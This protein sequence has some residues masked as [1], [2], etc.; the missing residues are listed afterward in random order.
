MNNRSDI[1]IEELIRRVDRLEI[2]NKTLR[3]DLNNCIRT[4]NN[5]QISTKPTKIIAK[6]AKG[7]VLKVGQKVKFVT[8]GKYKSNEGIIETIKET[9]VIS[10]DNNRNKIVRA[11]R[12]VE[13]ITKDGGRKR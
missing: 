2:E 3:E 4:K 8:K 9:R 7:N 1:N 10:I 11:H 13:V 6:D 5:K 12:N